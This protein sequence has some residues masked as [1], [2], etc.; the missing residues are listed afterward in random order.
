MTHSILPIVQIYL[1]WLYFN[2]FI[3]IW[4]MLFENLQIGKWLYKEFTAH[5]Q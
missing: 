1:C 5:I 2:Q 3:E 4:K